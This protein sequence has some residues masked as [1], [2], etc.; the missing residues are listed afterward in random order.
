LIRRSASL[1]ARMSVEKRRNCLVHR[2]QPFKPCAPVDA[3][4]MTS[5]SFHIPVSPDCQV[6][7]RPTLRQTSN[8]FFQS[9]SCCCTARVS[10]LTADYLKNPG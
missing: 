2:T 8:S 4:K 6:F 5:V 10:N 7:S 3:T 9:G 1:L